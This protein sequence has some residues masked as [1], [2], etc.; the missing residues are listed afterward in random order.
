MA[1]L[2]KQSAVPAGST[3]NLTI[4]VAGAALGDTTIVTPEEAPEPGLTVPMSWQPAWSQCGW[5]RRL[6]GHRHGKPELESIRV[7]GCEP[8]LS[9]SLKAEQD[10]SL[11]KGQGMY[12]AGR[13]WAGGA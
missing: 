10:S 4:N 12:K 7:Q 3:W 11:K 9:S 6:R 5:Q 13:V 1:V 2:L 8:L